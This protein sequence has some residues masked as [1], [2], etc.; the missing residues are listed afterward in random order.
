MSAALN[1]NWKASQFSSAVEISSN[2]CLGNAK[3][4]EILIQN[5]ADVDRTNR[6]GW[7]PLHFAARFGNFGNSK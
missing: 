7:T 1:G 2:F 6:Y 3:I 4:V 5:D